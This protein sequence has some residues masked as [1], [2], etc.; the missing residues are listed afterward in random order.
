MNTLLQIITV[1]YLISTVVE[2]DCP[3]GIDTC[4][5]LNWK[6][7]GSCSRTCGGGRQS[8]SRELCCK[9]ELDFDECIDDCGIPRDS[10]EYQGCNQICNNGAYC[11]GI[12]NCP[13]YIYG[14]C[15]ESG[16][17]HY[18]AFR[19]ILF[20]LFTTFRISENYFRLALNCKRKEG[21]D[22]NQCYDKNPHTHRKI[23][24]AT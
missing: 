9:A 6:A 19:V 18:Y 23:Q 22:L 24:K 1:I 14:R 20:R 21:T 4:D 10:R 5:W 11:N 17:S 12:C 7:W 16:T 15:C 13:Y 8:R 2:S 3:K